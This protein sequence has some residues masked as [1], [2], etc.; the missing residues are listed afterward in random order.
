MIKFVFLRNLFWIAKFF[1]FISDLSVILIQN[2]QLCCYCLCYRNMVLEHSRSY[3]SFHETWFELQDSSALS[4]I[5]QFY[6]P[7]VSSC[8]L[9]ICVIVIWFWN[10]HN[11][12]LLFRKLDLNN[13]IL[14]LYRRFISFNSLKFPL[15]MPLFL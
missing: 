7:K 3:S 11:Q 13:I 9:T 10:I 4:K 1:C 8:V 15:V 6:Q 14:L 2:F 12:I 5:Y